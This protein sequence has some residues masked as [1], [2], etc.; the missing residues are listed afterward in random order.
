M[1]KILFLSCLFSSLAFAQ[2]NVGINTESPTE[3]LDING[4]LRVRDINTESS[5]PTTIQ[6]EKIVVADANGVLKVKPTA[7]ATQAGYLSQTE[8]SFNTGV[9]ASLYAP[10]MIT[11]IPINAAVG[12]EFV[13][14]DDIWVLNIYNEGNYNTGTPTF[15]YKIL[16]LNR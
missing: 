1:K 14:V 9:N 12:Y 3:T 16:W 7:P 15:Y 4:S 10:V 6:N 13:A 11:F 5:T 2:K 8:G